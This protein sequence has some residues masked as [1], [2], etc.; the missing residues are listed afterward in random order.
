MGY[1]AVSN[2]QAAGGGLREQREQVY[3]IAD[4]NNRIAHEIKNSEKYIGGIERSRYLKYIVM[5]SVIVLLGVIIIINI[6][7]KILFFL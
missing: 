4:S 3:G 5:Y 2:M 1:E 6:L 7:S